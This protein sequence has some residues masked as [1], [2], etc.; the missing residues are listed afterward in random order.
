MA[1]GSIGMFLLEALA[2]LTFALEGTLAV[3]SRRA[4][5]RLVEHGGE[6]RLVAALVFGIITWVALLAGAMI[7]A[8]RWLGAT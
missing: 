6:R 8:G 5:A 1:S 4:R 3:F 7:L 2:P